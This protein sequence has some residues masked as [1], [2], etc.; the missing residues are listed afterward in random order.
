MPLRI[1]IVD[2]EHEPKAAAPYR[3]TVGG[4]LFEDATDADGMLAREVPA[5]VSTGLLELETHTRALLIS[6]LTTTSTPPGAT[7]RLQNLCYGCHEQ[8]P[9]GLDET[10]RESLLRLQCRADLDT[11]GGLDDTTSAELERQHDG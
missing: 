10:A 4:C 7:P 1:R 8:T 9:A 5:G 2:A 3:L 11:T 6:E